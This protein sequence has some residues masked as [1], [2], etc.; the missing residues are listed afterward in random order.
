[1][2]VI[3]GM[4]LDAF[5]GPSAN[6]RFNAPVVGPS[7]FLDLLE[8]HLGLSAPLQSKAH[9]TAVYLA[10][11]QRFRSGRFYE[12]SL[13]ADAVGT[14]ERLLAWRDEWCMGGWQGQSSDEPRIRDLACIEAAVC[15]ELPSGEPE[16][17]LAVLNAMQGCA[18][19]PISSVTL[20]DDVKLLPWLWRQVL[21]GLPAVVQQRW[22]VS[23][24]GDLGRVQAASWW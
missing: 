19:L 16:R 8:T 18:H 13:A 11:L 3:F 1:M 14:A 15:G 6:H 5:Q 2:H 23:A 22:D 9:R 20:V 4:D 10:C 24:Q 12:N 21:N 7:G 17:L